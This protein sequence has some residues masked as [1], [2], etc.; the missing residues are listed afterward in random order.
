M[1]GEGGHWA[2]V[3][4]RLYNSARVL[5]FLV[6]AYVLPVCHDAL[7]APGPP[8]QNAQVSGEECF[9]LITIKVSSALE[10]VGVYVTE[11]R[12]L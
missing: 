6:P 10:S 5:T 7:P 3:W 12:R 11:T 2:P 4:R 9:V 8:R 1:W